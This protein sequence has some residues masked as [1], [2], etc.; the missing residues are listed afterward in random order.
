MVKN[1][2]ELSGDE[3]VQLYLRDEIASIARPIMELK[4]F[5]RLTLAPGESKMVIFDIGEEELEF[6]NDKMEWVIEPGLVRIMIGSS[7]KDIRLRSH[8]TIE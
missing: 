7:S 5:S 4:G 3:L 6:L 2:G 8:L 1:I